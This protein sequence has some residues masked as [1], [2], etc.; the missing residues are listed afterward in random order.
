VIVLDNGVIVE[1][2]TPDDL[3]RDGGRFTALLEL[4]ASGW[5]WRSAPAPADVA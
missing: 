4:E 3:V 2:G 5:D 1:Q